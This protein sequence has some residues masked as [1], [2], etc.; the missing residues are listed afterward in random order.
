MTYSEFTPDFQILTAPIKDES[1]YERALQM[2]KDFDRNGIMPVYKDSYNALKSRAFD[3][4]KRNTPAILRSSISQDQIKWDNSLGLNDVISTARINP[5]IDFKIF[6]KISF[7]GNSE[8]SIK[9]R[10]YWKIEILNELGELLYETSQ[11]GSPPTGFESEE[12]CKADV[13]KYYLDNIIP[14]TERRL[15][16]MKKAVGELEQALGI[17]KHFNQD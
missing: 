13:R 3:Y 6:R 14:D 12:E 15:H 10:F 17:I 5:Q 7:G 8:E 1:S 4:R 2:I 16:F 11:P 9:T